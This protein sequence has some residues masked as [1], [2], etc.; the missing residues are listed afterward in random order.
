MITLSLELNEM[1]SSL[2]LKAIVSELIWHII[3][4][5]NR[6]SRLAVAQHIHSHN[7]RD[8]SHET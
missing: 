5:Y 8:L 4:R 6:F 1:H 7:T 2:V 3:D